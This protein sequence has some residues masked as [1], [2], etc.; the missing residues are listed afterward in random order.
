MAYTHTID[1]SMG[2][3]H[4]SWRLVVQKGIDYQ[5]NL[6]KASLTA[7]AN[8]VVNNKSDITYLANLSYFEISWTIRT[9]ND[10]L[11]SSLN[12]G[13][14]AWLSRTG[15]RGK[16]IPNTSF[17]FLVCL[18]NA[19]TFYR[20]I[21]KFTGFT[22]FTNICILVS[23]HTKKSCIRNYFTAPARMSGTADCF[24]EFYSSPMGSRLKCPP[25][26]RSFWA[27]WRTLYAV[28]PKGLKSPFKL[29]A[30]PF[31]IVRH[32]LWPSRRNVHRHA[33][34]PMGCVT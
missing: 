24:I 20:G 19:Q 34:R 25:A 28:K 12:P 6:D 26:V 1:G 4:F 10:H 33:Q 21:K 8:V 13:A 2:S 27:V 32:G 23:K 15:R 3:R 14:K 17:L 22:G 29:D 18:H 7:D 9:K 11:R 16:I 31:Q 30:V 5:K